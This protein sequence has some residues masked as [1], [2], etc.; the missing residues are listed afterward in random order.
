MLSGEAV[1]NNFIVISLR[2][3]PRFTALQS[4]KL[5]IILH[6]RMKQIREIKKITPASRSISIVTYFCMLFLFWWRN[7]VFLFCCFSIVQRT[8]YV[9]LYSINWTYS[10]KSLKLLTTDKQ[11]TQV[12]HWNLDQLTLF[13]NHSCTS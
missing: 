5:T 3:N 12:A 13:P 6:V 8:H 1:K 9:D 2:S 4:S 11:T 7:L 10:S